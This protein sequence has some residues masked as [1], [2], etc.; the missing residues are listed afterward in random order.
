MDRAETVQWPAGKTAAAAAS[1]AAFVD[2][3]SSSTNAAAAAA[4]I[5]GHLLGLLKGTKSDYMLLLALLGLLPQPGLQATN[6]DTG[7]AKMPHD[8][9]GRSARRHQ[10]LAAWIW[11]EGNCNGHKGWSRG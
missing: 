4:G 6:L 7:H 3:T 5:A 8:L 1:A 2:V 9:Q 10:L 11:L